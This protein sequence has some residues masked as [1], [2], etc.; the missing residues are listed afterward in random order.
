MA[1]I[2]TEQLLAVFGVLLTNVKGEEIDF[3]TARLQENVIR[4]PEGAGKRFTNFLKSGCQFIIGELKSFLTK[5]FN[6]RKFIGEGWSVWRGPADGDG[7]SGEEDVDVRSL[8]LTEIETSALLFETCLKEGDS[9]ITREEKLRRLKEKPEYIRLGGNVFLG[10]WL[11]YQ[12]N[13]ENSILENLYR[14]KGI[15]FLDFFGLVLR[16]PNGY[17]SVLSLFRYDDGLWGW[18]YSWL[19]V[20]W[21]AGYPSALLA[22]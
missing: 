20:G 18:S 3:E 2:T 1:K 22:K 17:R 9:R 13:K 6:P 8:S 19:D 21:H 7:L 4:D 10:L 12:A 15:K 5:P 14:T 11:D 16:N